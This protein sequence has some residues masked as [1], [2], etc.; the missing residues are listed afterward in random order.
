MKKYIFSFMLLFVGIGIVN[1][2][3]AKQWLDKV[4]QKYQNAQTYYIKFD[5]EHLANGKTQSQSGE[6]FAAKQKFNLNVNDVNQIFDGKKLI[7]VAKDDKEVVIS[8][9]TNTEDFLTPTKVLN[10][11]KTGYQYALDKKQTING[12]SIQLIKLTPTTQNSSMKYSVL[13]VN[14]K[15]NQI[16]SYQEFSKDGS[17][18]SIIVKEYLENLIIHKDYFN[19]DQ[20]K[21]KSKGYIVTQL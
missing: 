5:F 6:V 16:Y 19:F 8:N 17:K 20:K 13:G 15:N 3:T 7:T 12:Q 4:Q 9:A 18:T 21:Y 14:T 1:A 2:Q 11:Y 10:S